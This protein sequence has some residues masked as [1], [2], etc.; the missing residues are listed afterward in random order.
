MSE[1]LKMREVIDYHTSA[2][3]S[4]TL[5]DKEAGSVTV[6]AF[7]VG[8]GLSEHTAP[9]DALVY[10]LEGEAE[11]NING[12]GHKLSEGEYIIMPANKPHSLRA[13]SRFKMLLVM[14]KSL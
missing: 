5:I 14:I 4:R 2:I 6:F 9:Y 7:D 10:V 11:V 3:V 13:L 8:Q 1:K 12:K